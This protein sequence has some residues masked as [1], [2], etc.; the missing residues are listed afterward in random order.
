MELKKDQEKNRKFSLEKIATAIHAENLVSSLRNKYN[1]PLILYKRQAPQNKIKHQRT[2]SNEDAFSLGKL[3]ISKL[4]N[5]KEGKDKIIFNEENLLPMIS[6]KN[7]KEIKT[8][9]NTNKFL[10]TSG[11]FKSKNYYKNA[12]QKLK[13]GN[14][15]NFKNNPDSIYQD[16]YPQ[17]ENI[18]KFKDKYNLQL[19]LINS[20]DDKH[21]NKNY[22][23]RMFHK[24]DLMKYLYNKYIFSPT[25]I[26]YNNN[27]FSKVDNAKN[28]QTIN[29]KPKKINIDKRKSSLTID[30]ILEKNNNNSN[31][32]T[33]ITKLKSKIF[34][35]DEKKENDKSTNLMKEP[36]KHIFSYLFH[37]NKDII[38]HDKNIY[39][40]CLY[41]KVI[42][43]IDEKNIIYNPCGKVKTN[44]AIIKEPSYKKIKKFEIM[45]DK[46]I[47]NPKDL[48]ITINK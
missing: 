3:L 40:D 26:N 24:K 16:L 47:K 48:T 31:Q 27:N 17:T 41:S 25:D 38:T 15:M 5:S 39:V 12:F 36:N 10:V 7:S 1:D 13:L 4:Y 33:F 19:N 44:Y 34:K 8:N 6:S 43:K 14:A 2:F 37:K 35:N 42:S 28:M 45:I 30:E 32:N 11:M 22:A 21:K 9:T 46:V 29:I 23:L 18:N 20:N